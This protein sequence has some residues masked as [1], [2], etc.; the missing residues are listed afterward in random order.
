MQN[1]SREH[2][3]QG[4]FS[5]NHEVVALSR[6][7]R[8]V[9][10]L[11]PVPCG[12]KRLCRFMFCVHR[13]TFLALPTKTNA[14]ASRTSGRWFTNR[15][16]MC[17]PTTA[18]LNGPK[19]VFTCVYSRSPSRKVCFNPQLDDITKAEGRKKGIFMV[20]GVKSLGKIKV[21]E[22]SRN[23]WVNIDK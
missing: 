12:S 23:V 5:P 20:D 16:N 13:V 18:H 19:V 1:P 14:I 11:Q 8:Y 4:N 2:G 10:F 9:P 21:E 22:G 15:R 17:G 3:S 6:I 7:D